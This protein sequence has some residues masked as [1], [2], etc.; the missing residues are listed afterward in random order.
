LSFKGANF[1]QM[2]ESFV[3][4]ILQNSVEFRKQYMRVQTYID[5]KDVAG[6]VREFV[7][8]ARRL[9]FFENL[10][11]TE[12]ETTDDTDSQTSGED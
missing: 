4:N 11:S 8:L 3:F 10:Y 7:V 6:Y 1:V 2:S 12:E 9:V 5:K